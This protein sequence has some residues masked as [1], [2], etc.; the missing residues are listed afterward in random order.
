MNLYD[1][2]RAGTPAEEL[3]NAFKTE[4]EGAQAKIDAEDELARQE[5][6][7]LKELEEQ[8]KLKAERAAVASEERKAAKEDL[9]NALIHYL[10]L[11]DMLSEDEVIG[12]SGT[13]LRLAIERA[14]T[15]IENTAQL[16]VHKEKSSNKTINLADFVSLMGGFF[17]LY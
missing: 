10:Y 4:L 13:E 16:P 6:A 9:I 5:A 7:R 17:G 14:L 15:V 12:E 1:A 8:E 11:Y 2:L 3:I